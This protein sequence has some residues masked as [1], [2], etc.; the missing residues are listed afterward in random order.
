[1]DPSGQMSLHC[2][3]ADLLPVRHLSHWVCLF[4]DGYHAVKAFDVIVM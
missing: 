1:M 3:D 4:K 2:F